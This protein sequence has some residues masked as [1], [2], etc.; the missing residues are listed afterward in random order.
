MA[1]SLTD[2][3]ERWKASELSERSGSHTQFIDLCNLLNQPHPAASDP[4]GDTYTFDKHVSKTKGTKVKMTH[5]SPWS[6]QG[7][8]MSTCHQDQ[9]QG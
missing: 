1:L 6:V 8:H 5:I 4:K 9:G 3:V 7:T 2:F